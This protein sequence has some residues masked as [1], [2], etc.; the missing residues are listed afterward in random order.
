MIEMK[1]IHRNYK[2]FLLLFTTLLL[3]M[4][5]E[6]KSSNPDSEKIKQMQNEMIDIKLE[7]EQNSKALADQKRDLEIIKEHLIPSY[8]A[9]IPEEANSSV[10]NQP[11]NADTS[12]TTGTNTNVVTESKPTNNNIP[13]LV[14]NSAQTTPQKTTS[15]APLGTPPQPQTNALPSSGQKPP[16]KQLNTTT[17]NAIPPQPDANSL[18]KKALPQ[19]NLTPNQI[20]PEKKI[21]EPKSPL[22]ASPSKVSKP[23]NI[24]YTFVDIMNS[25]Y[26]QYIGILYT[27]GII[28]D[29]QSKKFEPEE[30]IS[31]AEYFTWLFRTYNVYHNNKIPLVKASGSRTNIFDDVPP[32]HKAYSYIQGLAVVGLI[33]PFNEERILNP[34][35]PITREE[36]IA[37]TEY[38][39]RGRPDY[40]LQQITPR[41]CNLYISTFVSDGETVDLDFSQ[42]IY[43]SLNESDFI[44]NTFQVF[45]KEIV[46]L[47]PKKAV[48]REQ[49][50]A[51]LCFLKDMSPSKLGFILKN[52]QK[53]K[54]K[55][56]S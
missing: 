22:P 19:K 11:S 50:A 8:K 16:S 10:Q 35:N 27:L 45:E 14:K 30:T 2:I 9:Q 43:R 21:N 32:S 52:G 20:V 54:Q 41:F 23:R 49:A 44:N 53:T 7:A 36:L 38:L 15:G 18:P 28:S 42:M 1:N 39:Q 12:V 51:S 17:N 56:F 13:A 25:P 6:Q 24:K 4:G 26:K 40:K 46:V 29:T 47:L 55:K 34:D 3:I 37:Y 48:T 31:K 33:A 5:C